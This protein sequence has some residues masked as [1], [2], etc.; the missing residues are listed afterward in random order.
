MNNVKDFGAV[1]DGISLDTK[2][3]QNAIDASRIDGILYR[4]GI[5]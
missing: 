2:A 4:L 5:Q 1:G 3:I